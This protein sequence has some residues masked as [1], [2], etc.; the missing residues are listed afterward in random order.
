M[1]S[2]KGQ[3]S[4]D[5]FLGTLINQQPTRKKAAKPATSAITKGTRIMSYKQTDKQ[6]MRQ[7]VLDT[8]G[9][10]ALTAREIAVDMHQRGL[11]PYPAR[12]IIQPRITEL[13]EAGV[14]MAIGTKL[15]EETERKVAVYKVV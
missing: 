9:N 5:D 8:L 13:V 15:D 1:E 10:S 11:L 12:A 2:I 14:I 4:I 7:H 6:P 3:T